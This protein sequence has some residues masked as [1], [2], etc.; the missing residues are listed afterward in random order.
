MDELL[1]DTTYILP[2][3]GIGIELTDFNDG[4][5]TMLQRYAVKYNPISIVEAKWTVLRLARM[6]RTSRDALL[7]AY[8]LGL[9]ALEKDERLRQT[10]LTNDPI[11]EMSDRLLLNAGLKDYFDRQVYSTA[12]YLK[13]LLLTEDE[14]LL[15]ICKSGNLPKPQKVVRWKELFAK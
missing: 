5:A 6:N 10:V 3:F 14:E 12:V 7:K 1:I 2:I 11:E 13:C 9:T 15:R 8:R 4:F